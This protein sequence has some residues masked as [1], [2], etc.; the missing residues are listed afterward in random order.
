MEAIILAGGF[1]TRLRAVVPDIPKP[2]APV[3]GRPFLDL[4]LRNLSRQGVSRVVLSLGYKAEVI[5]SHF[6]HRYRDMALVYAIEDAPLGTGG[7]VRQALAHC[8]SDR[9]VV[10]NGDTYLDI[11]ISQL[12]DLWQRNGQPL[13][14]AREVADTARYGRL[15]AEND[16]VMR[17]AEK[18]ASGPGLIN[19][20]C[21]LFP[22]YLLD[23]FPLG[24]PFSLEQDFLV[25]AVQRES[26]G[27]F[28]TRGRFIDIGV[29]EDYTRAQVE[30]AAL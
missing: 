17:F 18:A 30:L 8:H 20:G 7:A 23:A 14:V 21:Y 19:V 4:L 12:E 29:P 3:A 24:Q 22:K 2:M 10:L 26:F 28:V 16:R 13:I 27:L 1:G 11:E 6:G 5:T 15:E 9:A 25:E